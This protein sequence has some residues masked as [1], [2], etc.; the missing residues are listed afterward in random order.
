MLDCDPFL[1]FLPSVI[2]ASAV[3]LANH[4]QVSLWLHAMLELQIWVQFYSACLGSLD[5]Q[6]MIISSAYF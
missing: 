6:F 3:A 5:I 4:T 1:R 2:A